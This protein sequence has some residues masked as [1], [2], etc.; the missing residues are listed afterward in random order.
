MK[1][2]FIAMLAALSLCLPVRGQQDES[3]KNIYYAGQDESKPNPAGQRRRRPGRIG[4]MVKTELQRDGKA[5][6]VAPSSTFRSGD[7][8]RLHIE[9]N[10]PGYLTVLNQGTRGDLQLLYP[11]SVRDANAPITPT[12]DFTIPATSGRWLMF[13]QVTG[14][15]RLIVVLS[16]QPIPDVLRAL[17]AA[18]SGGDV[19]PP[20]QKQEIVDSLNSKSFRDQIEA[21]TSKDLTEV[22]DA[23]AADGQPAVFAVSSNANAALRK[24]IVYRLTLRHAH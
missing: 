15:E 8:L 22:E 17:G 6:F 18:E 20:S 21:S 4:A 10:R 16:A 23:P 24:P 12:R 11:K 13:D 5:S 3:A 7:R 19:P 14:Q 9:V 1:R 2:I